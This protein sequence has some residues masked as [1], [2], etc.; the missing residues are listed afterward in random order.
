MEN[1]TGE[2]ENGEKCGT[3][4]GFYSDGRM[5]D[6]LGFALT[7]HGTDSAIGFPFSTR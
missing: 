4:H 7:D 6:L 1:R 2:H 3:T 5:E